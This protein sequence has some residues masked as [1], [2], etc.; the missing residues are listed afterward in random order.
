MSGW[1]QQSGFTLVELMVVVLIIG[2]LV[3]IAIPLFNSAASSA[4]KGTCMS[5]QRVIEG[6]AQNYKAVNHSAAPVAGLFN[7]NHTATT[8][9]VLVHDYLKVAPKCPASQAFYWVDA[10]GNVTGD[11]GHAGWDNSHVHY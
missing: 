8:W 3:A 10:S 11:S 7:G 1:R 9:D 5:N 6:A 2:I 4:R